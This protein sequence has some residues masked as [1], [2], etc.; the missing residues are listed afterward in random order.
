MIN[1][2]VLMSSAYFFNLA[3]NLVNKLS[4]FSDKY[5]LLLVT[6]YY[7]NLGITKKF[8]LLSTEKDCILKI[9]I[10]INTLKAAGV[11][12]FSKKPF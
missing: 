3:E 1:P 9:L 5:G 8:N 6:R 4:N 12:M 2:Q 11:E 7:G 10:D